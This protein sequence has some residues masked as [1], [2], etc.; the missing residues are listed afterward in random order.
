ML[1]IIRIQRSRL[2]STRNTITDV[3]GHACKPL[4]PPHPHFIFC[5]RISTNANSPNNRDP[6]TKR[7]TRSITISPECTPKSLVQG[8]GS[9]RGELSEHSGRSEQ[10]TFARDLYLCDTRRDLVVHFEETGKLYRHRH[11]TRGVTW[12]NN[13]L[14]NNG[15]HDTHLLAL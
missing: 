11:T 9:D 7:R 15:I 4:S 13:F 12:A 2:R 1:G 6:R 8:R 10:N 5:T 14:Y 3:Y